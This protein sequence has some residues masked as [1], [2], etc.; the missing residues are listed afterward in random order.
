VHRQASSKEGPKG[1][2]CYINALEKETYKF[3]KH[4][5]I[6]QCYRYKLFLKRFAWPKPS[7]VRL[8]NFNTN[9][10]PKGNNENRVIVTDIQEDFTELKNGSLA[11]KGTDQGF[12]R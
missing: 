9:T 6:F 8:N 3:N 5:F 4:F 12:N 1:F 11:V 2:F 7:C 10:L